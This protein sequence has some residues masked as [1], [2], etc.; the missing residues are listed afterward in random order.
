MNMAWTMSTGSGTWN[1]VLWLLGF[2]VA[3]GIAWFIRSFGRKDFREGTGQSLPFISG[4]DEPEDGGGHIP[5]SNM[6]WGFLES[7]KSYYKRIV[8]L[9]SGIVTDYIAWFLGVMALMLVIGLMT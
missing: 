1:P 5:A 2:G 6:Y 4:N 9:H 8:P 7:M 3:L